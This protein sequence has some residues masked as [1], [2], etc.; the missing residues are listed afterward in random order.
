MKRTPARRS[1]IAGT[2]RRFLTTAVIGFFVLLGLSLYGSG[3]AS[4]QTGSSFAGCPQLNEGDR[5]PCVEKLQTEL[6]AVHPYH[7][8]VDG[9]F[10]KNTRIA[11][12]DFQGRNHRTQPYLGADGR[13]GPATA[14]ELQSQYDQVT[15]KS[16]P[17]TPG[18]TGDPRSEPPA[19]PPAADPAQKPNPPRNL[20]G[21]NPKS[22]EATAAHCGDDAYTVQST[23]IIVERQRTTAEQQSSSTNIG[24]DLGKKKSVGI[25]TDDSQSK[26]LA[27][28]EVDAG[29]LEVRYSPSCGVVWARAS[30][31]ETTALSAVAITDGHHPKSQPTRPRAPGS[32]VPAA[33]YFSPM[34]SV[35][36]SD[37]VQANMTDDGKAGAK[38]AADKPHGTEYVVLSAVPAPK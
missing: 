13:F 36:P 16:E 29:T 27:T 32:S 38:L 3:V 12:L 17:P 4:A 30:T 31:E 11:L 28:V 10:G 25:G 19:N 26:Q 21:K 22:K 23:P 35:S 2:L 1:N 14:K 15:N 37:R 20:N 7:L 6:N 9:I 24:V 33:V 8:E 18:G 5:G 34:I